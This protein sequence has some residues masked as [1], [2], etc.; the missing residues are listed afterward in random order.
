MEKYRPISTIFRQ[1][2]A[3]NILL[4]IEIGQITQV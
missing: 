1:H 4:R 2:V 3:D